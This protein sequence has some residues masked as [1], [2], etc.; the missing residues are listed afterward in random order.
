MNNRITARLRGRRGVALPVALV[1]LVAVSLLVTTALLTSSTE[2]AISAAHSTGT[3]TLYDA[4]SG[5]ME[6]VRQRAM[7]PA[8]LAVGQPQT[9]VLD[10]TEGRV[11]VTAARL[12][13]VGPNIVY[14]LTAQPVNAGGQP[15]GRAV[16]AM[17]RQNV[18]PPTPLSTNITSAVTLGGDLR[19]RGNAF[20]I[21]GYD[22]CSEAGHEQVDVQAV[23]ASETSSITANNQN[24][25]RN[26]IGVDEQGNDADGMDA[27]ERSDLSRAELARDVLGGTTVQALAA[28]APLNRK[29]GPM[30]DRPVWDGT[31]EAADLIAVVD[32]NGGMVDVLGGEG[33]L[34]VLNGGIRMRGNASFKGIIIAEGN[35]D[36]AGTPTVE[37]ALIS[38]AMDGQN[39]IDLDDSAIGAGHVT[40]K[41]NQCEIARAQEAWGAVA[42]QQPPTIVGTTFGWYEVVR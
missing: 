18:P 3:R 41:F 27:I 17:I 15:L 26:F 35:F 32:A 28:A 1:G 22:A 40:V 33:L 4:E 39:E 34:L 42:G 31:L 19:V 29:W 9:I 37:G 21:S 5:L 30:W 12:G 11:R 7:N 38:L 14:A 25:M 8:P 13:Q 24:H 20:T 23:R 2:Y 36:L 6:F 16:V 10:E